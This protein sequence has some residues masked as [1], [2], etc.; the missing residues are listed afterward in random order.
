ML[1]KSDMCICACHGSRQMGYSPVNASRTPFTNISSGERF[2]VVL[3]S[4]QFSC[5]IGLILPQIIF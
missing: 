3:P 5:G 1:K 4:P 2:S